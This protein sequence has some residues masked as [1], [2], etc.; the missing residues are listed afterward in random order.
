MND[1]D[2]KPKGCNPIMEIAV[3]AACVCQKN[4]RKCSLSEPS[5]Q[6]THE[7]VMIDYLEGFHS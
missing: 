3:T 2:K 4:T 7:P 5:D 1:G 6:S